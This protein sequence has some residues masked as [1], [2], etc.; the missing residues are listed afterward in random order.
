L[1]S[2]STDAK[3]CWR[4]L[5]GKEKVVFSSTPEGWQSPVAV[6]LFAE[7]DDRCGLHQNRP[8]VLLDSKVVGALC[9]PF[10]ARVAD[11]GVRY[12]TRAHGLRLDRPTR[13]W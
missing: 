7:D 13:A 1:T 2:T 10:C 3:T 11:G 5:Q 6:P 12:L 9:C 4:R 8:L